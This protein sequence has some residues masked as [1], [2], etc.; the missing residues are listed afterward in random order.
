MGGRKGAQCPQPEE[1]VRYAIGIGEEKN[2]VRLDVHMA[3]C[4]RCCD[5]VRAL[6]RALSVSAGANL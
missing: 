6:R 2:R 5:E 1:I 3:L 4:D